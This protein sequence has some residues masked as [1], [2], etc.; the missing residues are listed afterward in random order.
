M[1]QSDPTLDVL[2]IGA[3]QAGLALGYHLK[4]SGQRFLIVDTHERVGDSWRTRFDSLVL[5]TPRSYSALPG[6]PVPGDPD[7]YPTKDE[8][9]EYLESYARHFDLPIDLGTTIERLE[10]VD[11]AFKST[12][13]N[14]TTICSRAVVLATG[15]FQEPAVPPIGEQF[16][17]GV[18]QLTPASYRNPDQNPAG[19][20]LVVGDG[21]T[22]R[23]IAR[24]LSANHQVFLS[25]GRPRKVSPNRIL[26][27]NIFWWMDKL[28]L[29]RKSR[30][31]AIGR[32]LMQADPFPG[33]E[34]ELKKLRA[35]GITVVGRLTEASGRTATFANG[36]TA[37]IDAVIWATG[38]R[39]RTEWVEIPAVKDVRG[40]FIEQRGVS[41]VPG[42]S[43]IGRSWQWT[44][45]SALL[46]GVG[47]DAHYVVQHLK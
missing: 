5:F 16:A 32:R 25:A 8:I 1:I 33:K 12:G 13:P 39:D 38:Y 10:Q 28:G 34:L 23:Q 35:K 14:G 37:T 2:V 31:S 47:D 30:T 36:Q 7:T 43:F 4:Q 45:G 22:G 11:G 3:G 24:E 6:L 18:M 44:R 19:T 17:A 21:A 29:S 42:L 27:K 20:V 15:A 41:P 46:T 9:A 40:A 26:G